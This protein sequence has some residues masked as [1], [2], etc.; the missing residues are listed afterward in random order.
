M[1]WYGILRGGKAPAIRPEEKCE[2]GMM[3]KCLKKTVQDPRLGATCGHMAGAARPDMQMP[4][5]AWSCKCPGNGTLTSCLATYKK[6]REY[7]Q[8]HGHA[9]VQEMGH[10]HVASTYRKHREYRLPCCHICLNLPWYGH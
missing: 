6:H 5:E 7:S 2:T 10:L 4:W 8:E 3:E 1:V 9:N